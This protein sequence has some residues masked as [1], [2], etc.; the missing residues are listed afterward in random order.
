METTI[1]GHFNAATVM[2]RV[3]DQGFCTGARFRTRM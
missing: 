2:L 1:L 3:N